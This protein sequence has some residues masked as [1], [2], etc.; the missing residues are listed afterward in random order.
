M[1]QKEDNIYLVNK[2]KNSKPNNQEKIR[3]LRQKF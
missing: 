2:A 1:K 3:E